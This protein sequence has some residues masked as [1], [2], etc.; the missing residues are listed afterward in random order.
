M[1]IK[2]V[3]D[4]KISTITKLISEH[5]KIGI[6]V[7]TDGYSSYPQVVKNSFCIH[8]IVNISKSFKNKNVSHTNNIE[9]LWSQPKYET[10]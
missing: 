5:V 8:K 3:P 1:I 4:R 2:I 10:E 6:L 7:I 9:N